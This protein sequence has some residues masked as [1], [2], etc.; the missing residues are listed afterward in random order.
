ML[1]QRRV[2]P[3]MLLVLFIAVIG[4]AFAAA[5][6][7]PVTSAG[8]GEAEITGYNVTG[9][10]YVLDVNDPTIITQVN[11]TVAPKNTTDGD[12][13]VPATFVTIQLNPTGPWIECDPAAAGGNAFECVL[14]P[15]VT[16]V[17]AT[18]LRVVAKQ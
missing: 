12:P 11:M 9:V 13:G 2:L 5:N 15:T 16:T 4:Y 18:N 7:V 17:S 14:S 1:Q 3:V 10:D 6:T 8:D